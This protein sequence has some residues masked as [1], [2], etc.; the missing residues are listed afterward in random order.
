MFDCIAHDGF[1]SC[2]AART[3]RGVHAI[4]N[5]VALKLMVEPTANDIA[6]KAAEIERVAVVGSSSDTPAAAAASEDAMQTDSTADD[7]TAAAAADTAADDSMAVD[8]D[9]N[10]PSTTAAAGS[11]AAAAA[12]GADSAADTEKAAAA[13]AV[14]AADA[15]AIAQID[16]AMRD[17]INSHLPESIRILDIVRVTGG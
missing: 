17:A 6:K 2:R 12:T 16:A 14:A 3:D 4:A 13:A 8:D 1:V 9:A 15:L 7:I 10:A 5:V 11:T